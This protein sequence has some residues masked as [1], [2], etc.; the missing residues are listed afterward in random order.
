MVTLD[1]LQR[2]VRESVNKIIIYTVKAYLQ[3][4]GL[5]YKAYL[6]TKLGV[7]TE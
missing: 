6:C 1:E 2:S 7:K 5:I 4:W 3:I